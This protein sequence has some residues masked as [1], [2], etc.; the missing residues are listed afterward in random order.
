[1]K[2]IQMASIKHKR[3][4]TNN[5]KT[6][7]NWSALI[8]IIHSI[9]IRSAMRPFS[10]EYFIIFWVKLFPFHSV[11]FRFSSVS[12]AAH[13]YI[14]NT[15]VSEIIVDEYLSKNQLSSLKHIRRLYDESHVVY[16]FGYIIFH[17]IR[18]IFGWKSKVFS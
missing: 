16:C 6:T 12:W 18:Y 5:N 11:F 17:I 8:I 9:N 2:W 7:E 13:K 1:M 14:K 3:R 10:F 15:F 4:I